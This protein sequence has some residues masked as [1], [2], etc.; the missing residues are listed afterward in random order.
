MLGQ[1][2]TLRKIS[3]EKHNT[4]E[5]LFQEEGAVSINE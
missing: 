4:W 1:C 3:N 2:V 5:I